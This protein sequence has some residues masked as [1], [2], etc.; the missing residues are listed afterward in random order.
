MIF[1]A[2]EI[3]RNEAP[4]TVLNSVIGSRKGAQPYTGWITLILFSEIQPVISVSRICW[5]E[6]KMM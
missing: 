4:N 3:E 2:A 5:I 1:H 6:V